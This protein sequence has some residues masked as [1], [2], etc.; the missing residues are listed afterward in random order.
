MSPVAA[1]C[2]S[3]DSAP[4]LL[5]PDEDDELLL[6]PPPQPPAASAAATLSDQTAASSRLRFMP[7]WSANSAETLLTGQSP[8]MTATAGRPRPAS[9]RPPSRAPPRRGGGALPRRS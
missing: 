7:A 4:A 9:I 8:A 2:A 5:P 6:E 1:D 3:A